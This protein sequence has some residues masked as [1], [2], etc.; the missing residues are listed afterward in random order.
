M[1]I[2][3]D[4]SRAVGG[5]LAAGDRVDVMFA[6]DRA[7]SIIVADAE[8]LAVDVSGRGGIG[9]TASP[10]TV[11]IAV[12]AR[13]SQLVAAAIA[14]GDISLARTTGARSAW[15]PRRSR[16]IASTPVPSRSRRRVTMEPT[17]ALVFSP[18]HWV[19]ELHRHL[20]DHGGARV[21]QIVL[22][23]TVALDEEF[24]ML[25]VSHRWP[26]LT[27]FIDAMHDRERRVLG[28]F[29]PDEAAGKE[30]LLALG[31]DATIASDA[32]MA[33]F[34][35]RT[36]RPRRRDG[37]R[38]HS[39][40]R[41][42]PH[43][44]RERAAG[45]ADR[46]HGATWRRDH[47]G[48]DQPRSHDGTSAALRCV[49]VDADDESPAVAGTAR[50]GPRAQ[51]ADRDR[52]VG[53]GLG[54]LDGCDRRD[55]PA[56]G[57]RVSSRVPER[58]GRGTGTEREVLDVVDTLRGSRR[59]GR[60]RCRRGSSPGTA[61]L[62]LSTAVVVVG[63]AANPVGVVRALEWLS[64]GPRRAPAVPLHLV[65]NRRRT[66]GIRRDEIPPRSCGRSFRASITC[67][68]DRPERR[69]RGVERRARPRAARS[70]ACRGAAGGCRRVR[71]RPAVDARTRR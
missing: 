61:V 36:A 41:R 49:L 47:R 15:A 1:S 13:Q 7:V 12:T 29:D 52:R 53:H 30:H 39:R 58:R 11:T 65:V 71:A 68:P 23:P 57:R 16:S 33:E 42:S 28:V 22:E 2:P 67:V 43:R 31:V 20:T 59:P 8:V 55:G 25:V 50:P 26:A 63:P 3:V 5:R 14:D 40:S 51:P 45:L 34:V 24:D 4:P 37:A 56:P 54:E 9:E 62:D 44:G 60:D 10:F 27:R 64:R 21:R 69:D 46:G 6:G 35:G 66:S 17:I 48:R 18:E 19:E 38:G 70:A 32:A